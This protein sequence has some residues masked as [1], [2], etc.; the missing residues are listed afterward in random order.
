MGG[1]VRYIGRR[2]NDEHNTSSEPGVAL[3]DAVVHYEKGPWRLALNATNLFNRDY[4]SICYMGECYR[5]AERT[6]MMTARYRW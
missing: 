5:G 2:Q 3:A 1:G 4:Y 6:L